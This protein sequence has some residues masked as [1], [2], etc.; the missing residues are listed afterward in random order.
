MG[1]PID[2]DREIEADAAEYL[3]TTTEDA[4]IEK[5]GEMEFDTSTESHTLTE[6]LSEPLYNDGGD[7]VVVDSIN[8]TIGFS[9]T[10]KVKIR[11]PGY[12]TTNTGG[13]VD[14]VIMYEGVAEAD[15]VDGVVS[16]QATKEIQK[17]LGAVV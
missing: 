2:W 15:C 17:L 14:Q 7:K 8:D 5:L 16:R 13:E 9:K 11:D 10:D 6:S 12:K 3:T 4:S 1:K